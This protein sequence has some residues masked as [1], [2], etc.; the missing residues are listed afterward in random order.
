ME[1]PPSR[2][3]QAMLQFFQKLL[4]ASH[5][6]APSARFEAWLRGTQGQLL[7]YARLFAESEHEAEA[8]LS[9]ALAGVMQAFYAGK[10]EDE[11]LHPYMLRAIKNEAIKVSKRNERRQARE[12]PCTAT[13]ATCEHHSLNSILA[14]ERALIEAALRQLP[15]ELSLILTLVFWEGMSFA[16]IARQHHIPKSTVRYRYERALELLRP[17]L[18][19]T[20]RP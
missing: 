20:S 10:V 4:P 6:P 18:S 13:E 7:R 19:S 2:L 15:E 3:P 11:A 5:Q 12:Q 8:I 17:L 16:D 1:A 14:D 9:N